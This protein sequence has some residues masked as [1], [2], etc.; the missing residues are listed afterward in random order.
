[1]GKSKRGGKKVI[2][3]KGDPDYLSPTQLRNRR[4]R[5]AKKDQ[6]QQVE[7]NGDGGTSSS[8][9][10]PAAAAANKGGGS[11]NNKDPSMKYIANP[12]KAPIVQAAKQYFKPILQDC[13]TSEFHV[14]LGPLYQW[15]TVSKLAVRP[16]NASS[17]GNDKSSKPRVAI[18]LFLPQS[19]TL[20]P[21][22]NCRA[23]HPSI[24]H[25]VECITK[26][27]HEVGVVP[28]EETGKAKAD[29]VSPDANK[30]VK[31]E[32]SD[33]VEKGTGQLRYVAINVAR[34]TGGA[35]ITL[36]WNK[37]P[38]EGES[39]T[40]D[41]P[42][43][44]KLV[45]K[46]TSMSNNETNHNPP[47]TE[48]ENGSATTDNDAGVNATDE[49]PVK[50][51]R[52]RGR[53]E[54][55]SADGTSSVNGVGNVVVANKETPSE[56]QDTS[57]QSKLPKLNLHSLWINYNPSW[58]HSNAIFAFDSSCWSHVQGPNAIV[59]NLSFAKAQKLLKTN[60]ETGGLPANP[61]APSFP[62]PLN[63][64]P[65]VFRQA[66]IDAFTNIVG[67][68]RERMQK[69]GD[70]N[71][72]DLACVELYGGVGTIGLHLSD[73]VSS[74][75]SSDENPNN[76]KCFNESVRALPKGIQSRLVYKQKNA[77]V[78][79]ESEAA[80]FQKS[81]VLIVDPPRKGLDIEVVDYLCNKGYKNMK[82]V[83]YV[84]CGF[85]AFQR[86]CNALTQSG[87]WKVEFAEGYLLFPGSDAIETLAFFVPA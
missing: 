76:F 45:Q 80:L 57:D 65:N 3:K 21:V 24:N 58:K 60:K 6:K 13:N 41:D 54:E 23:H 18:G 51:R 10:D 55:K 70:G 82:L 8:D 73:V 49:Q 56:A 74:L 38:P 72:D 77:A 44:E 50:K 29:D 11:P 86:D 39:G 19:H 68:I 53:R 40:I 27:C 59:E 25:A 33:M 1:M 17:S 64:P 14:H 42:V 43:L 52:R 61:T 85:Q 34:E 15:R 4:K 16:E 36:V 26:V 37:P 28:Y 9:G 78:M 2:P 20:L 32:S 87:K 83:V 31:S 84:S 35:Q 12:A 66:N 71:D 30:E 69:L 5:R 7:K 46:L 48:N 67:R 79:V 81:Q 62:I 47:T 75:V 63:F 22:P